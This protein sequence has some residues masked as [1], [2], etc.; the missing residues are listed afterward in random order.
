MEKLYQV[1]ISST[2]T[3]LKE[4]RQ[5]VSDA[6]S[7]AGHIAQGMELFPAGDQQQLDFIKRVIDRSDYY[8]LIV[9]GRYGSVDPDGVS[10]T[11][12][13]FDYAFDKKIPILAFLHEHPETLPQQHCEQD[14]TGR[15]RLNNFRMKV[16]TGRMVR[17][18]DNSDKLCSEAIIAVANATNSTPGFGWVRGDQVIDPSF[19]NQAEKLRQENDEMR[20]KLKEFDQGKITF[21]TG[22]AHGSDFVG[23]DY[24]IV[25]NLG[26]S[27]QSDYRPI[28]EGAISLTYDEIFIDI[29]QDLYNSN[30]EDQV[31]H[32]I[33]RLVSKN[34][35]ISEGSFVALI[36]N[37]LK[38]LR[39]SFEHQGLILAIL[40]RNSNNAEFLSWQFT[41]KGRKYLTSLLA[42]KKDSS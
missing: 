29:H 25:K 8:V 20:Q 23:L 15:D 9:A 17:F 32:T 2:F 7:K 21:P 13:E 1:F 34:I 14:Q 27:Y 40:K 28:S 4:E 19:I 38:N 5:K 22:Y 39:Y 10:Y 6:L 42:A 41:E 24:R 18:W 16:K 3:D 37:S 35:G 12:R 36:N 26:S 30:S 33:E 11:E 31:G